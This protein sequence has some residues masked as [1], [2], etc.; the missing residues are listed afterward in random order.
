VGVSTVQLVV[1]ALIGW[2]WVSFGLFRARGGI[3]VPF[4]ALAA[5]GAARWMNNLSSARS[6]FREQ[7][8][9][10]AQKHTWVMAWLYVG[11]FGSFIGYSAAF[12]L[13]LK[14]QFPEHV[15]N[16]AFVGPLVG[17]LARPLGGR[18]ADRFGGTR[19]TFWNFVVMGTA[20]LAAGRFVDARDFAGFVGAF[21]LLFVTAGIGNGTT[22][23][24]IPVIFRNENLRRLP[25]GGG[26]ARQAALR[27]ARI[28]GATV[29]GFVSA[30]GA[31]GGYIVPRAFGESIKAT[32]SAHSALSAFLLFY[33]SCIG[34]TWALYMRRKLPVSEGAIAAAEAQV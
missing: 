19:M 31:C 21:L 13:L 33:A 6:D 17:S 27:A 29:L 16:L 12:P 25:H 24:M 1:P 5:F 8:A 26:E 23:R 11:T 28:Q 18:L 34:L 9:I 14:T 7:L 2:G 10:T 4:I 22:F 15:A 3:W 20:A 32:G 30:I